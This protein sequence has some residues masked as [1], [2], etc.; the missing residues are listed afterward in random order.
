MLNFQE[1][2]PS[3]AKSMVAHEDLPIQVIA[4]NTCTCTYVINPTRASYMVVEK[5]TRIPVHCESTFGI[6]M[7]VNWFSSTRNRSRSRQ[8]RYYKLWKMILAFQLRITESKY[9]LF[10]FRLH[11]F[12]IRVSLIEYQAEILP[13]RSGGGGVTEVSMIRRCAIQSVKLPIWKNF[14]KVYR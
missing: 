6:T 10:L 11:A 8:R 7:A 1:K 13:T 14:W 2:S 12:F 5:R 4:K 3:S 9:F